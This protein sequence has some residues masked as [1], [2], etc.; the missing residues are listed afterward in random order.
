MPYIDR[1]NTY[2]TVDVHVYMCVH[3][4][5]KS[6]D[7]SAKTYIEPPRRWTRSGSRETCHT[8]SYRDC[9]ARSILVSPTTQTS[10]GRAAQSKSKFVDIEV[11]RTVPMLH[12]FSNR[13]PPSLD[14]RYRSRALL[15]KVARYARK[16]RLSKLAAILLPWAKDDLN[17]VCRRLHRCQRSLRHP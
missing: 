5:Y 15:C 14:A 13:R 7:C 11:S 3:E 12:P 1:G 2:R 9:L 4:G 17:P 6:L 10:T 8:K 16:P